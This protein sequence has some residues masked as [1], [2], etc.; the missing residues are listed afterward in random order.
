V[1][2]LLYVLILLENKV[3]GF[4]VVVILMLLCILPVNHFNASLFSIFD[5][6]LFPA[7]VCRK[8]WDET[9]NDPWLSISVQQQ[10]TD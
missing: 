8:V 7:G 3:D 5:V 1:Q 2:I 9:S 6:S 4:D 10:V